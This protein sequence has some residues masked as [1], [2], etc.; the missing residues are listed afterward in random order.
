MINVTESAI[1]EDNTIKERFRKTTK[2]KVLFFIQF[3]DNIKYIKRQ[4]LK[5]IRYKPEMSEVGNMMSQ[6]CT[7]YMIYLNIPNCKYFLFNDS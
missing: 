5:E 7:I 3:K 2:S 1:Y 4:L 6:L